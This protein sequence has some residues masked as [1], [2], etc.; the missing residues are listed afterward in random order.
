MQQHINKS[1]ILR[2]VC[3]L[4]F[5]I[6]P[7]ALSGCRI[8]TNAIN[9]AQLDI[10]A[11][12]GNKWQITTYQ[13]PDN[14]Q[15]RY[16]IIESGYNNIRVILNKLSDS[17]PTATIIE[18]ARLL[19][20]G[21]I[22]TISAPPLFYRTRHKQLPP[23]ISDKLLDALENNKIIYLRWSLLGGNSKG[24]SNITNHIYA[25]NFMPSYMKCKQFLASN[26]QNKNSQN[27]GNRKLEP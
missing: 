21:D 22:F 23:N 8:N 20:P 13:N 6:A 5:V 3:M 24:R 17:G 27:Y 2:S 14:K 19:E 9:K 7:L 10:P 26:T 18:T 15:N 12:T 25:K 4:L 1:S 16:C 11:I